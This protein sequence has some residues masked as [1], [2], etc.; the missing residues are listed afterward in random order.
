MKNVFKILILAAA[1]VVTVAC[2]SNESTIPDIVVESMTMDFPASQSVFVEELMPGEVIDTKITHRAFRGPDT[3]T[4]AMPKDSVNMYV[5]VKGNATLVA[6]EKN[7]D[8]VPESIAIPIDYSE[9]DLVIEEGEVVHLLQF[10][11]LI[12]A[13]DKEQIKGF[14]EENI[15]DIY[16]AAFIDCDAY[17][18]PIKSPNTVSRTVLH[19][20][21]LPR[22]ALG[23]VQAPGPDVVGEHAHPMLDQLFLGLE[24]NNITVHADGASANLPEFALLHIPLGSNHGVTVDAGCSLYYLWMD[25]FME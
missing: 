15:Y 14:P 2:S 17:V 23:T 1:L 5:F 7:F 24:G 13:D 18:E 12:T 4:L 9:V 20:D 21:I 11:K 3:Y 25:F 6:G 22:I 16:F 19:G 10:S 8:V